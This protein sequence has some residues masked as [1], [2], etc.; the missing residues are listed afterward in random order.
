MNENPITRNL[1]IQTAWLLR[2]DLPEPILSRLSPAS[3]ISQDRDFS[4]ACHSSA[5]SHV[6]TILVGAPC[7]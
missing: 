5:P 6:T 7:V 2:V 1:S 4:C 3:A